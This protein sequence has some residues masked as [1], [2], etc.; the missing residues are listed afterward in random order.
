MVEAGRLSREL[1]GPGFNV[2]E[3]VRDTIARFDM[4]PGDAPCVVAVS[5]GP[6]SLC[7]LDILGRLKVRPLVVAHVDHG[8]SPASD[9]AATGV[10]RLAAEAGFDVHVAR[11]HDLAGPNLHARA[12]AFRYSFFNTIARDAGA[13]R[14]ATGHTLDDRVETTLARLIHGGGTS[15]LAG[16]RPMDGPRVRP[17][18]ALRRAET[19]RYCDERELP[20]VVDDAND[21]PRFER[22]RVRN[23]LVS[24]IEK[25]WGDGAV[26]AIATSIERLSE[27]ATALEGIVDSLYPSLAEVG[28]DGTRFDQQALRGMPRAVQRR[29]LE[30]AVGRVRDRAGGIDAAL[31]ALTR[32]LPGD[33]VRFSVASGIEIAIDRERVLV[34]QVGD[35]DSSGRSGERG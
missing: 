19:R 23:E 21:D 16:L 7:L 1:S 10:A 28:D 14:I 29:L 25:H 13:D 2:L 34:T 12:R 22:A 27:D 6:D 4:L 35:G 32:E 30:R 9:D 31:E 17:L 18:I 24:A 26:R 8:L 5:G 33:G 3:R 20:Y 15:V 11:A